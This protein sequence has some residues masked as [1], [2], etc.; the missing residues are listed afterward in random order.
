MFCICWTF[1]GEEGSET[2][3]CLEFLGNSILLVL[4]V[5]NTLWGQMMLA[6]AGCGVFPYDIPRDARPGWQGSVW[7][8]LVLMYFSL[9]TSDF[10][11]KASN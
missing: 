6:A 9:Q 3:G 1:Y 4:L 11:N 5:A 2:F 8:L 10:F 7:A